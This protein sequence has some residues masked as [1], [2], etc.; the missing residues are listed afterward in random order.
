MSGGRAPHDR[1]DLQRVNPITHLLASWTLADNVVSDRRDRNLITW[2]GVLPDLDGLGVVADV[3][4]KLLAGNDS[5]HY[6]DY[7]HQ[8]LHGLPGAVVLPA[9][10][11]LRGVERLK[12]FAFGF[13][14]V[15]LHLLCDLVGSRGPTA[16]DIW[17]VWYLAPFSDRPVLLWQGQWPLNAWPN[18]VFTLALLAYAFWA[19][20]ARGYCPVGLFSAKADVVVVQTL[21]TRWRKLRR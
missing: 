1:C 9:L 14:A 18:V 8:L 2:A 7:H 21:R 20:V 19:A 10:L 17:P 11:A 5:W 16:V 4:H 6:G 12:V 15:H 13:V 3:G